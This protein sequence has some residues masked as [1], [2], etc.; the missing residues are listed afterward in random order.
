MKG[1]VNPDLEHLNV[2]VVFRDMRFST[3]NEGDEI[4][5]TEGDLMI[6]FQQFL[7]A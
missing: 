2:P 6:S 5:F 4:T 3:Y 7:C 1:M